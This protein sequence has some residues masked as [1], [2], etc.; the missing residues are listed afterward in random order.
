MK[1]TTKGYMEEFLSI[2]YLLVQLAGW[3]FMRLA[4]GWLNTGMTLSCFL[5]RFI[6]LT[7]L[8]SFILS[9]LKHCNFKQICETERC[10]HANRI[11]SLLKNTEKF[12]YIYFLLLVLEKVSLYLEP[13][14]NAEFIPICLF[15]RLI[16]A[17]KFSNQKK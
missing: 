9:N 13:L 16:F 17:I 10:S 3:V 15:L 12:I 6:N 2:L 8:I 4:K 5:K 7:S 1:N 14:N 11:A